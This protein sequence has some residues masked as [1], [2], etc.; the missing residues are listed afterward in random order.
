MD[1][2]Q[3]KLKILEFNSSQQDKLINKLYQKI[4]TLEEIVKQNQKVIKVLKKE[5]D[6]TDEAWSDYLKEL[7]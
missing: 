3:N 2:I 4:N 5:K 7:K 1:N 6:D